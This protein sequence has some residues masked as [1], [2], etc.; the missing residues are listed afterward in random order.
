MFF[1]YVRFQAAAPKAPSPDIITNTKT[2]PTEDNEHN[3]LEQSNDLITI[4]SD[5]VNETPNK[6]HVDDGNS[7]VTVE[8]IVNVE[9]KTEIIS[10]SEPESISSE[11]NQSSDADRLN[12]QSNEMTGMLFI[13]D[14]RFIEIFTQKKN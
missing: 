5:P 14:H 10:K 12:G 8:E 2:V 1:L 13:Y 9:I 11:E 4:N 3:Q 6:Q 7:S